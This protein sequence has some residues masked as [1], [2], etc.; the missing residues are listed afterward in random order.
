MDAA[1]SHKQTFTN[2][3]FQYIGKS[4]IHC[5]SSVLVTNANY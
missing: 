5:K 1:L 2:R 3:Y 4:L